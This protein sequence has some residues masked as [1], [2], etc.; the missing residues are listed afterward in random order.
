MASKKPAA[1]TASKPNEPSGQAPETEQPTVAEATEVATVEAD[2]AKGVQG[3]SAGDDGDAPTALNREAR[4]FNR[5]SMRRFNGALAALD[6]AMLKAVE[7]FDK[8]VFPV[9][10]NGNRIEGERWEYLDELD[11]FRQQTTMAFNE[12]ITGQQK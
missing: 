12:F 8:L 7:E 5:G 9:D 2:E 11:D 4:K 10:E 3:P 1:Q 6:A